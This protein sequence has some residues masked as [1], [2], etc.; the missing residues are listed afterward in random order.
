MTAILNSAPVVASAAVL[1]RGAA[2]RR[3]ARLRL[4]RRGRL[5][6]GTLAVL[7]GLALAGALGATA[8]ADA[9]EH[10]RTFS[11]QTVTVTAG[12]T[13]WDIARQVAPDR[14]PRDVVAEV[15]RLNGLGSSTLR[16]GVVLRVP[17]R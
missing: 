17:T 11:A 13:L 7:S 1:R 5:V 16:P 9:S 12:D 4:T 14:D 6:L 3:P 15:Q 8:T 10:G 2:R